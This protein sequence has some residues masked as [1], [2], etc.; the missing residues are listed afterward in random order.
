MPGRNPNIQ[1]VNSVKLYTVIDSIVLRDNG[2]LE[3]LLNCTTVMPVLT[4]TSPRISLAVTVSHRKTTARMAACGIMMLFRMLD[5][6]RS[7][8]S[9]RA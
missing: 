1:L 3:L 9:W 8:M 6:F 4:R 2:L 5:V 7:L